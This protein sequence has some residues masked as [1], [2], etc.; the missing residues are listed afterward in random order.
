MTLTPAIAAPA[1]RLAKAPVLV[2]ALG[3]FSI[4]TSEFMISGLLA[5]V[6]ADLGISI[7]SAGLLITGYAGGV[8]LGGPLLTIATGRL[9]RK[10]QILLLLM[11]FVAGNLLC[12]LSASYGMLLAGRIVG[13]FCHGAFY[14][15]ASVAAA[16]L[17]P[18]HRRARA[19][20]LVSAG[21]MVA[22]V[23]GVPLGT[24]FGQL[25]G[26]RAAFWGVSGL[27][28]LATAALATMLPASLGA[29]QSSLAREISALL[30]PRVLTGLTL[31]LCFTMGLF[32][33]FSYL[34]PLLVEVSGAGPGQIPQMLMVFGVGAT[35]GMLAGGRLADWR[36]KPTLASAFAAQ[37]A[38][39]AGLA[40]LSQTLWAMWI[41]LFA[42]GVA[43]MTAVAPL[44]MIVLDGAGDAS[45]LASTMTSSTFNLGVALGAALGAA[46]LAAGVGYAQLPLAGI[47]FAAL[48]LAL[49][50]RP[51]P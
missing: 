33:S 15:S 44:R 39:Y 23:I 25:M 35:V 20:A 6:A 11:L 17:V 36:P 16:A 38:V 12:A 18:A 21:V 51:S 42:L 43:S 46:L 13:A 26:W 1:P 4:G 22:N 41:A 32:I 24:A 50:C 45:A 31:G 49:L 9:E 34:T 40:G 2:L 19:V 10:R 29:A 37:I 5:N 47:A 30:R 28:V 48:G 27:G 7:P 14:G 3:A 8:A